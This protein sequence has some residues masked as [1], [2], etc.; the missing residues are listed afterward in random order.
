VRERLESLAD[1]EVSEL[2]REAR[3]RGAVFGGWLRELLVD[4]LHEQGH[5]ADAGDERSV[6][7]ALRD[8][9][10]ALAP[11]VGLTAAAAP[12][13]GAAP[14][15]GVADHLAAIEARMQRSS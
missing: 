11:H 12:V 10:V 8:L 2:D 5:V 1:D 13:S 14:D 6:L 4:V 3:G 9:A 7:H 15:L